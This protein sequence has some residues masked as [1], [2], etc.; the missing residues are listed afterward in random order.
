MLAFVSVSENSFSQILV[1]HSNPKSIDGYESNFAVNYL[2]HF[3]F[4]KLLL[5]RLKEGAPSRVINVSS[6]LHT[7]VSE[8]H[9]E[10]VREPR[11]MVDYYRSKLANVVF[12]NQ[13]S[14]TLK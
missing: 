12:S 13:L 10:N 5:D 14:R 3:L 11:G 2:G 4:T 7:K 6:V 8:L 1:G 9:L